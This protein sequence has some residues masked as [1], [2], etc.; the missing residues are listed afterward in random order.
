MPV[1]P[2]RTEHDASIANYVSTG[3]K[4]IIGIGA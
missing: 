4:K 1:E 2:Y 3:N